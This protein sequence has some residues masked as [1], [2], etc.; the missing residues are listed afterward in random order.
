[1]SSQDEKNTLPEQPVSAIGD[2]SATVGA[3]SNRFQNRK[4]A[5]EEA[6]ESAK[7]SRQVRHGLMLCALVDIRRALVDLSRI[8][9]GNRFSLDL[10]ADDY[11]GWPRITV[12]LS[13]ERQLE[14]EF[15][16]FQVTAHDRGESGTIEIVCDESRKP[17]R[18]N[19]HKQSDLVNL[20]VVL[21]SSVRNYLDLVGDIVMNIEQSYQA[22]PEEP[23]IDGKL[24]EGR[25]QKPEREIKFFEDSLQSADPF[26]VLPEV[27]SL[28]KLPGF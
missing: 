20:A 28:D 1:M 27:S 7:K 14:K 8:D 19:I 13:D 25:A 23:M 21:K 24:L 11:S 15:S 17:E 18:I 6:D 16:T 12:R 22:P 26:E 2:L 4:K 9:L 10:L 3:F 5:Q